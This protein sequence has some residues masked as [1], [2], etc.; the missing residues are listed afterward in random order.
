YGLNG[1]YPIHLSPPNPGYSLTEVFYFFLRISSPFYRLRVN[2]SARRQFTVVGIG[3]VIR[4]S[5][6]KH[7]QQFIIRVCDLFSVTLRSG[8]FVFGE[9]IQL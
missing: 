9:F 3:P 5:L 6:S 2:I 8:L 1:E 4:T 7:F